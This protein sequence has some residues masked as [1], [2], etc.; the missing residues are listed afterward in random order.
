MSAS[1]SCRS[2]IIPK[3]STPASAA[4]ERRLF[5]HAQLTAALY[6]SGATIHRYRLADGNS[7]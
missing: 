6:R 4:T 3:R 7:S 1:L 5:S 2:S